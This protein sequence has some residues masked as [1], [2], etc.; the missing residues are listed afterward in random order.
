MEAPSTGNQ[1]VGYLVGGLAILA[2]IIVTQMQVSETKREMRM[3][4]AAL[5]SSLT[6]EATTPAP[7]TPP[8]APVPPVS[9]TQEYGFYCDRGDQ[10][11]P[12]EKRNQLNAALER[13]GFDRLQESS[14]MYCRRMGETSLGIVVSVGRVCASPTTQ[15]CDVEEHVLRETAPG[16][17]SSVYSVQGGEMAYG[18]LI[19][20][21]RGWSPEGVTVRVG[22]LLLEGGCTEEA[23]RETPA[24]VDRFIRFSDK[25]VTTVKT[26]SIMSCSD[27]GLLSCR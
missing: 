6:Q 20:E 2:V 27:V 13:A 3:M 7:Q 9:S 18:T 5:E 23:I 24:F 26:C 19:S 10:V 15:D 22:D 12:V 4:R 21:V 8:P 1:W 16:V 14:G 25:T 17:L 11:Q